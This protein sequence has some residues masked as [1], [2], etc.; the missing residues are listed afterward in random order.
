LNCWRQAAVKRDQYPLS[1]AQERLLFIENFE[2]G[3]NAYHIPYFVQLADDVNLSALTAAFNV[4]IH[5]HPV[6]NSVY[7]RDEQ[8]KAYQ[9]Q[10]GGDIAI[11]MHVLTESHELLAELEKEISRP[12]DLTTEPSIR[13]H[14]YEKNARHYL[15]MLF[16]KY[17]MTVNNNIKSRC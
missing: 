6:L 7:R 8:N 2:Q 15:L 17:R 12:F 13:L 4:V 3:S 10:L 16:H 5:R 1:F 14:C 9:V 11:H